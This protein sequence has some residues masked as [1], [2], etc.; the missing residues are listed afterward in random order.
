MKCWAEM[1]GDRLLMATWTGPVV[2]LGA[3]DVTH[4][5]LEEPRIHGCQPRPRGTPPHP[6]PFSSPCLVSFCT[7]T[8]GPTL[9]AT[10][11]LGGHLQQ[12]PHRHHSPGASPSG[13]A[14]VGGV[15][16][17]GLA[18]HAHSISHISKGPAQVG[19]K[20]GEGQASLWGAGEGFNLQ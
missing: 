20:D 1:P 13:G 15:G 3:G 8:Q 16:A 5:I 17:A 11:L 2:P 6:F 18:S 12:C 4:T 10:S 19:T 9:L 7:L 14:V